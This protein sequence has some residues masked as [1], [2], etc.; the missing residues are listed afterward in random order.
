M[1]THSPTI[2]LAHES[3]EMRGFL[4]EQ[5]PARYRTC[6]AG[7]KR[8]ALR[9]LRQEEPDVVVVDTGLQ[10]TLRSL[11]QEAL[12]DEG[13]ASPPILRLG[14]GPDPKS[15][16]AAGRREPVPTGPQQ[17]HKS[18]TDEVIEKPFSAERLLKRVK[19][20]LPAEATGEGG[21]RPEIV[22]KAL[23]V[24]DRRLGDPD[25]TVDEVAAAV[26]VSG[27]HLTRRV[28]A[29]TESTPAA[30]LR[31]RRIEEAKR[32]LQADPDTIAGVAEVVGFRSPS[33]FSQVF[34][35]QVGQSP[36]EYLARIT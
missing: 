9:A 27:R 16:Q 3:A 5:F 26:G 21:G 24:M 13:K 19:R 1:T 35:K 20:H 15:E 12:R 22:R 31:T 30:L 32:K 17:A 18:W 8:E 29:E 36:S 34:Q 23:A 11:S 14:K 10:E 25:L 2:L 6:L 4:A 28:K 7:G 33:H